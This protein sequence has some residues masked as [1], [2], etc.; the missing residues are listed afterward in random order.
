M[1]LQPNKV[2]PNQSL[3]ATDARMSQS[4]QNIKYR[5]KN[6]RSWMTKGRVTKTSSGNSDDNCNET[7][8]EERN[9]WELAR[10]GQ[11]DCALDNAA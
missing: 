8:F 2:V 4:M 9:L 3:H 11:V 1:H 7:N 6:K 10:S 5:L